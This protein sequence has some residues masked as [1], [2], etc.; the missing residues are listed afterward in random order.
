MSI[1]FELRA[2]VPSYAAWLEAQDMVA[3]YQ[4]HHKQLQLLGWRWPGNHWLLKAPAH[5]LNLNALLTV[6]PDACIV[7]T[8]RDPLQV[9]PSMCSLGAIVRSLHTD[10]V[11]L[12]VVGEHWLNRLSRGI[13]SEMKVRD[14]MDKTRLFNVSYDSLVQDPVDTIWQI[15]EYFGYDFSPE[16][17]ARLHQWLAVNPQHKHGVHRYSLEQFHL[18]AEQV[19][20]A[21][22]DYR[23]QL[24]LYIS[25]Q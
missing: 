21:F 4:Y 17:A 19:N 24:N 23:Q 1:M 22:A 5:L 9:L 7:Q 18:S 16:L 6:Y 14:R 20:S 10:S 13:Q 2:N 3:A 12:K 11:D 25:N 15:Y 8:H